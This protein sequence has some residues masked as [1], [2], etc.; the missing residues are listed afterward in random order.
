[1]RWHQRALSAMTVNHNNHNSNSDTSTQPGTQSQN[2][3][4]ESAEAAMEAY[5][6]DTTTTTTQTQTLQTMNNNDDYHDHEHEYND[7]ADN[8][9]AVEE[10]DEEG[11]QQAVDLEDNN[12]E[13]GESSSTRTVIRATQPQRISTRASATVADILIDSDMLGDA[14]AVAAAA[15]SLL[16]DADIGPDEADEMILAAAAAADGSTSRLVEDVLAVESLAHASASSSFLLDDNNSD[17]VNGGSDHALPTH[18]TTQPALS[19]TNTWRPQ[20]QQ[21]TCEFSHVISNY[22]K[23]RESGCKK[24]EYSPITVDSYGNRWRLIVYVNGNGRASNHHLSLFL[25][26]SSC[27]ASIT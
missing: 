2:P 19:P 25:Q 20:T 5:M 1:M 16:L 6:E 18:D 10:E 23:K 14:A 11:H 4:L 21:S 9:M 12:D 3:L 13:P 7:D 24:A 17:E 15:D 22:S 27:G 8:D 26:V